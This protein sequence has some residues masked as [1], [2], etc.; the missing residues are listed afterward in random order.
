M[1]LLTAIPSHTPA[2]LTCAAAGVTA[3]GNQL[4]TGLRTA[5][6]ANAHVKEVRGSGLLVGIQLDVQAGP[7]VEV[8][9]CC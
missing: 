1:R 3:R 8:R 4:V 2:D 9:P 7:V 5:L 6:A